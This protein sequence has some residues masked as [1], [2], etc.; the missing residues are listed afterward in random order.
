MNTALLGKH[1]FQL[2]IIG[3]KDGAGVVAVGKEHRAHVRSIRQ[4]AS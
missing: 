3:C 4:G 1:S 2:T